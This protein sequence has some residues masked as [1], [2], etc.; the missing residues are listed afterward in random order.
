M[1]GKQSE[2]SCAKCGSVNPLG[3][4]FCGACGGRLDITNMTRGSVS[5]MSLSLGA[6]GSSARV[7]ASSI[8]GAVLLVIFVQVVLAMTAQSRLIGVE[9]RRAG[10]SN[11]VALARTAGHIGL[12]QVVGRSLTEADLNGYLY[13]DTLR[14]MK[15][16]AF[17][18]DILPG[19][20]RVR[21]LTKMSYIDVGSWRIQPKL[22]YEVTAIP[23]GNQLR[24]R[25]ARIGLLPVFGPLKTHVIRKLYAHLSLLPEWKACASIKEI[26]VSEDRIDVS[27]QKQ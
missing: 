22:S 14:R 23:S 6:I 8:G 27:I 2:L 3:R 7:L 26:Q 13:G 4:V 24:F 9:G 20:I 12:G 15:V 17:S 10:A 5:K 25:K 18:A 19:G 21:M 11:V 1:S 16:E